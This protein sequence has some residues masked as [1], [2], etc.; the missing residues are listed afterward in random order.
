M[1]YLAAGNSRR[2]GTNKLLYEWDGRPMYE[3]LF[4]K[5]VHLCEGCPDW[6]IAVVT[7]YDEI[8]EQVRSMEKEGSRV[9]AVFSPDSKKGA[10]YSIREG[11]KAL[12]QVTD[13]CAFFV[14]DQPY[15][16][17][18]SIKRFLIEMEKQSAK[19]GSVCCQNIAGSPTWFSREY[20]PKLL[21]LSGDEGGRKILRAYPEDVCYF[22]IEDMRELKDIDVP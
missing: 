14:A 6:R 18:E 20:Y 1:I 17:E 12:G 19:L 13:A 3:H 15:L 11:I 9:Q 4:L 7:Q 10:A 22:E 16:R 8:Y 2:F 5:L 21:G